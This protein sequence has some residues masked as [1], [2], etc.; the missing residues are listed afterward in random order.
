MHLYQTLCIG[1]RSWVL[2]CVFIINI[3]FLSD[4]SQIRTYTNYYVDK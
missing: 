4:V 3:V 1:V 2:G